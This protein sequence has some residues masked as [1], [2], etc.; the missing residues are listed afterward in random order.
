MR[1]FIALALLI[2]IA[3]CSDG[4]DE[5]AQKLYDLVQ[6]HLDEGN[7]D[8]AIE[9]LQ[10]ITIDYENTETARTA[11]EE[12]SEYRDL[13]QLTMTTQRRSLETSFA[14][15]G[16]ALENYKTRYRAYPIEEKEL[17]KLP[18][19]LVPDTLDPWG[20]PI[21]YK[22]LYSSPDTP[23][24]MPDD[25]VLGSFGADGLPGGVDQNK[26]FFYQNGQVRDRI[27]MN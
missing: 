2:T 25:Y 1:I 8:K 5:R 21:Y 22:P 4:R 11:E 7:Y 27:D 15:L 23:S 16:R 17:E 12:I 3:A 14:S 20:N 24:R 10:R 9:V 13:I 18:E 26:D 19:D 6:Y